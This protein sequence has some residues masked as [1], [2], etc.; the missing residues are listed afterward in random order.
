[1]LA[2]SVWGQVRAY[3]TAPRY[4][5]QV[6]SMLMT[7][8]VRRAQYSIPL[9]EAWG[10]PEGY[11]LSLTS[12]TGQLPKRGRFSVGRWTRS[13]AGWPTTATTVPGA[14][15]AQHELTLLNRVRKWSAEHGGDDMAYLLSLQPTGSAQVSHKTVGPKGPKRSKI[16]SRQDLPLPHQPLTLWKVG[17]LAPELFRIWR[18]L[19]IV[20]AV[21][22]R[23]GQRSGDL[24]SKTW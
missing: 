10:K 9:V 22:R 11:G 8:L 19:K 6:Y 3:F 17:T 23:V 14:R 4:T 2:S 20:W 7:S 12:D 24:A 13:A 16:F 21:M 15:T 5:P 18:V 1:M